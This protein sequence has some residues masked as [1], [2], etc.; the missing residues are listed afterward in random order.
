MDASTPHD[1][2]PFR[3]DW[4]S[5]TLAGLLLGLGLAFGL[6]G[7]FLALCAEMP[8]SVRAQLGMWMVMPIWVGVLGSVYFFS[9]GARAW[10]WLGFANL[11]LYGGLA[12]IF[13]R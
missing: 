7:L 1:R 6:S 5:K 8:P 3:R 2:Q 12:P 10:L 9:S 11:V 13:W 4:I